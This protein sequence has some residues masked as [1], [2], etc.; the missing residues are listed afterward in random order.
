MKILNNAKYR[1][2]FTH[3]DHSYYGTN[4]SPK[5]HL[6]CKWNISLAAHDTYMK[7]LLATVHDT[8]FI[9]KNLLEHSVMS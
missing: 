6:L 2:C 3:N 7:W 5:T 1:V 9:Q 8:R 4:I